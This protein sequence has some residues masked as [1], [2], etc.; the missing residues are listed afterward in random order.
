MNSE[1]IDSSNVYTISSSDIILNSPGQFFFKC[2][3]NDFKASTRLQINKKEMKKITDNINF[4]FENIL[5][6]LKVREQ[7]IVNQSDSLAEIIKKLE[8]HRNNSKGI[9]RFPGL[10]VINF[11]KQMVKPFSLYHKRILI[12]EKSDGVRYLMITFRNGKSLFL[13]RKE[14]FYAIDPL[15]FVDL[16][17]NVAADCW[18]IEYM[19]DGELILDRTATPS[20]DDGNLILIKPNFSSEEQGIKT[21]SH[22]LATGFFKLNYVIFDAIVIKSE[23]IGHLK[24]KERLSRLATFGKELEFVRFSFKYLG[25]KFMRVFSQVSKD[26]KFNS[27]IQSG[28][29]FPNKARNGNSSIIGNEG[30]RLK[31]PSIELFIKDYFSFDK[32]SWIYEIAKQLP[33]ENDGVILNYDDYPYYCGTSDEVFKFKP[34]HLNTIDFELKEYQNGLVLYVTEGREKIL[35]VSMFFLVDSPEKEEFEEEYMKIKHSTGPKI[36]ECF[37]DKN[38]ISY[39]TTN[40]HYNVFFNERF[41]N[42]TESSLNLDIFNPDFL[43]VRLRDR[44]LGPYSKGST[45]TKS[46][47][48]GGW[49]FLRFRKDKTNGNYINTYKNIVETIK[50]DLSI[51]NIGSELKLSLENRSRNTSNEYIYDSIQI[52]GNASSFLQDSIGNNH[53]EPQTTV[54][55]SQTQVEQLN[56]SKENNDFVNKKRLPEEKAIL[57]KSKTEPEKNSKFQLSLCI[58]CSFRS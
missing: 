46:Y 27:K 22:K 58:I 42:R 23:N 9:F 10:Q 2:E 48:L 47:E 32:I 16:P 6:S 11:T 3:D 35:P 7:N 30:G 33:H 28:Y 24:F 26:P 39:E 18:E 51:E 56:R 12:C 29:L 57:S 54:I 43:K 5:K 40:F 1:S 8:R 52:T 53:K 44:N 45:F 34:A 49:R 14:E 36:I 41:Y 17:S 20:Q 25:D 55:N 38:K 13:N 50:E 21:K 19:F 15:T 4:V 31:S 37:Y